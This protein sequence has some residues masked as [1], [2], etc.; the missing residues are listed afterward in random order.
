MR[1]NSWTGHT[2]EQARALRRAV[3][4]AIDEMD[5]RLLTAALGEVLSQS[6]DLTTAAVAY[7][8]RRSSAPD[9]D[10]A[11]DPDLE[12]GADDPL[13]D[14]AQRVSEVLRRPDVAE[15]LARFDRQVDAH[16]SAGG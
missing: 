4:E 5:L 2:P 9:A 8:R 11:A 14:G 3:D 13:A 1:G 6:R 7:V 16:L 10:P 15:L 12:P